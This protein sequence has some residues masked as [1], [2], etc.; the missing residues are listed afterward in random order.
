MIAFKA[1]YKDIDPKYGT[2]EDVD[3]LLSELKKRGMKLMMDLVVN[4]TSDQHEWFK[5]SRS[6]QDSP[7][8]D[9]YIWQDAKTDAS[10]KRVPPNNWSMILGE[11]HSA[12]TW[13]EGS[14]QYFLAL[15]TP[16]QPDLNW[17]N[18][19]VREAVYDVMRFWLDKG[20]CGFRM[21]VINHISKVQTFPD[22]KIMVPDHP[23]QPG[24]EHYC[25]GPR[26]HEYIKGINR[27]VLS[28]Y[29]TITVGEM[30]F[31]K[32]ESS[33][34]KVVGANEEEL[35]MIFIFDMVDID[36]ATYRMTLKPWGPPDIKRIVNK[37]Q[38][39]MIQNS[40]WN[41]LF[42]ENHDNPRSVSRYTDDSDEWREIGAKLLTLMQ[43]TLCGTLYVYQGEEIGMRNIPNEWGI[44]EYKD[45][46]TLNYYHK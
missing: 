11:E 14:Q 12:W 42:I 16:E 30:P 43:S 13:D 26:L 1:D 32:D 36:D 40:G 24:F 45:V 7:Y 39:Y 2:L 38:T 33:I 5:Q 9:W 28:H 10:G 34:L 31:I 23:Y 6:S 15:F 35:R 46:E 19:K 4:H 3:R 29:D 20:V 18:P 22:A 21:D 25:N 37:W 41:S 17:E 44:E 8:R 27:N